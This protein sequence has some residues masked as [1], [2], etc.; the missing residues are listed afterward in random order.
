MSGGHGWGAG[1]SN[2]ELERDGDLQMLRRRAQGESEEAVD[3][4]ERL[5]RHKKATSPDMSDGAA[6]VGEGSVPKP[7]G[8][9]TDPE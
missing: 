7:D 9:A 8:L 1:R 6:M 4:R 2:E 3:A 5:E